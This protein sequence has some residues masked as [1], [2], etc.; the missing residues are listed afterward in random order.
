LLDE[1]VMMA[2]SLKACLVALA[3]SAFAL[4]ALAANATE[5]AGPKPPMTQRSAVRTSLKAQPKA[6]AMGPSFSQTFAR[7]ARIPRYVVVPMRPNPLVSSEYRATPEYEYL[8]TATTTYRAIPPVARYSYARDNSYLLR[9]NRASRAAAS[10][11]AWTYSPSYLGTVGPPGSLTLNAAPTAVAR[12]PGQKVDN[13]LKPYAVLPTDQRA[14]NN[15]ASIG[16][17]PFPLLRQAPVG[18]TSH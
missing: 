16:Q 11:Y 12:N 14:I 7:G 3:T 8:Y 1:D 18:A 6:A 5:I 13:F 17:Q 4:D 15:S 10:A 9:P 2:G